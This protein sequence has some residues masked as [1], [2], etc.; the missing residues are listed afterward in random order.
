MGSALAAC[1]PAKGL[2]FV[3]DAKRGW[4]DPMSQPSWEVR[5]ESSHTFVYLQSSA[6]MQPAIIQMVTPVIL[7]FSI[8][9]HKRQSIKEC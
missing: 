3:A 4:N 2:P 6:N 8:F 5:E 1:S 7:A 9:S